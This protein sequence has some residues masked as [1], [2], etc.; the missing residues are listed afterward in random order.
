MLG[1]RCGYAHVV[2]DRKTFTDRLAACRVSPNIDSYTTIA[3]MTCLQADNF[4]QSS[5]RFAGKGRKSRDGWA[6]QVAQ[7]MLQ[8]DRRERIRI[9]Q[10]AQP[11]AKSPYRY[12]LGRFD[13]GHDGAGR[14][15]CRAVP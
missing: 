10:T 5:P 8:D 1:R 7:V 3:L 6:K 11:Q 14:R 4:T 2:A 9:Q 12:A 15:S 13:N